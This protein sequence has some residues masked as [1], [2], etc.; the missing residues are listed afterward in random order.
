MAEFS[1]PAMEAIIHYFKQKKCNNCD[2]NFASE[3][4]KLIKQEPKVLVV[5][6]T[7][8]GCQHCHGTAVV[9]MNPDIS[10]ERPQL[11]L[12]WSKNDFKRLAH[13]KPI[14]T[15]D[16]IVTHNFIEALGSDW[17]KYIPNKGKRRSP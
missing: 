12:D 9:A 7:C 3:S 1:S 16:I 10:N 15:D 6:I 17:M 5:Q 2:E 11:P 14:S 8:T 4:I 13:L